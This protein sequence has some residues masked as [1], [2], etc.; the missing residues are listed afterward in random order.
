MEKSILLIP[1]LKNIKLVE[2]I[3]EKYDPLYDK[4]LPHITLVFPFEASIENHIII[5]HIENSLKQVK[6]TN[7]TLSDFSFFENGYVFWN[8][9]T[10]RDSLIKMNKELYS[11]I[12]APFKHKTIEYNPHIT[13][14]NCK[15]DRQLI[16]VKSDIKNYS[17][18]EVCTEYSIVFEEIQPNGKSKVIKKFEF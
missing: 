17:I 16:N 11:D 1:N 15:D 2:N 18:H 14:A 6:I 12:L 8:V 13:I 7:F 3:R 4:V 5:E 9:T 10:G